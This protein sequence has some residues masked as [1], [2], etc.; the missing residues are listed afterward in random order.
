[1]EV[2]LVMFTKMKMVRAKE[3]L[4]ESVLEVEV[5]LIKHQVEVQVVKQ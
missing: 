4:V 1:M 5:V 2:N 3:Y